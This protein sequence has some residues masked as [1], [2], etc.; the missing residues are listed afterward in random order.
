MEATMS[1]LTG[2][3]SVPDRDSADILNPL[4]KVASDHNFDAAA[5]AGVINTE[6]LW[7]T[8]AV[9]GSYIGLT[10]VGP[11]LPKLLGLTKDQFLAL[12]ASEQIQAYG[13][14][15]DYYHYAAQIAQYGMSVGTQP[16]A[17]QAAVLQAMQFAP[18][19]SKWKI[20]FAKGDYSVPATS[21]KQAHFL[22]DTSIHDM[23]AYYAG[24]FQQ[25]PPSYASSPASAA[26]QLVSMTSAPVSATTSAAPG[27]AACIAGL[28]KIAS[29]A[30]QLV[31]A[32]HVAA[33]LLYEYDGEQYPSDGCAIT[34]SVLLQQAGIAVA[35]TYQAIKLG[36]ILKDTRGW[37]PIAVGSQQAGDVGST[38]GTVPHHGTDHIYLVLKTVNNDEMVIADNQAEAPHF[39][40]ASGKGK[41]PTTFF[42][43]APGTTA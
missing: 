3:A 39:R 36:Q 14:W 24:F 28:L 1:V 33:K 37:Q 6:S 42:L 11:E 18:N 34:L 29:N 21:S 5:I 31:A 19:G 17:R 25:H 16:V 10:Q 8:E 35:N 43:R 15:L 22:G 26:P 40:W 30:D 2:G 13:K 12:T 23:E 41:S 38:C 27:D 4:N 7:N 9:S 32:Q 20:A